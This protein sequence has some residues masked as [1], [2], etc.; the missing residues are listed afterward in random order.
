MEEVAGSM[1]KEK[2]C[3]KRFLSDKSSINA[4]ERR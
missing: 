1:E 4:V 2:S 3:S